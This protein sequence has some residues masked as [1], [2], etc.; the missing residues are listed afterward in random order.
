MEKI[1]SF[2]V[3]HLTLR[4]GVYISR[5]DGV[6]SERIITYD[7]R[8]TKPN[9]EPV[10]NTAE[11]HTIEHLGATYLRNTKAKDSIIYFGPMGCRTGFYLIVKDSFAPEDFVRLLEETFLYI[12]EYTGDIPG[13][14]PE[15]CGNYSD[16]NLDMAH[17]YGK[18]FLETLRGLRNYFFIYEG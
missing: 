17:F 6:G 3:N 14:A 16:Q 12:S 1:P 15:D 5:I 8:I 13:A 11:V 10:M 7:L 18:K 2:T 9:T 4:P